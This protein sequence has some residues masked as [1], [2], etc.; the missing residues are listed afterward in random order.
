MKTAVYLDLLNDRGSNTT[1][2]DYLTILMNA[3]EAMTSLS[4]MLASEQPPTATL[5]PPSSPLSSFDD[6]LPVTVTDDRGMVLGYN[7]APQPASAGSVRAVKETRPKKVRRKITYVSRHFSQD[8]H[9]S[10]GSGIDKQALPGTARTGKGRKKVVNAA[11]AA[12]PATPPQTPSK[13]SQP[14]IY[15]GQNIDDLSSDS[16]LTSVPSSIGP[17]PFPPSSPEL[18]AIKSKSKSK[19]TTKPKRPP[20]STTN[21]KTTTN[22]PTTSP[23]FPS[24]HKPRPHFLST[25]PFPPLSQP[26]FGLMQ[27]HL[28]HDPFRLLLATIFLNKTPGERAMPVFYDLMARYPSISALAGAEAADVVEVIRHLGFQNQRARKIVALARMWEGSPP[29]RGRRYRKVDYPKKGDGRDVKVDE[30]LG[31][32]E[33]DERVAWEISHLPGIGAYG[34]DSWRMFCRDELLGRSGDE[35]SFEPEWKRVLPQDKELRA[36]MTW[37]WLKEGWVWNKETG[38]RTKA[39][40]ELMEMAR[41]G[42]VVVE[43][44][45]SDVLTLQPMRAERVEESARKGTVERTAG[46]V[47][48]EIS[49]KKLDSEH[50]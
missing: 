10:N 50:G 28:R 8:D 47:L 45:E 41:G 42:G 46:E 31:C 36:W 5:S 27:E 30:V 15:H 16:S 6:E 7:E 13:S 9:S 37:M 44:R 23:Y 14:R 26:T 3:G 39:S 1:Q 19:S 20:G 33:T 40:E 18:V 34:H 43:E 2:K 29:V 24:P 17:D 12:T 48:A 49:E 25:L 38:E 32:E 11:S 22:H 4:T 35:V 21:R